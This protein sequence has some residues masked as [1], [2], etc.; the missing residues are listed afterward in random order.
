MSSLS[1]TVLIS[2]GVSFR[3]SSLEKKKRTHPGGSGW[4]GGREWLF[5]VA[6]LVITCTGVAILVEA[7]PT[8][9]YTLSMLHQQRRLAGRALQPTS[10]RGALRLAGWLR[11]RL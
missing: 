1:P 7:V 8:D 11:T 10:A 6:Q 9:G 5:P 2:S 3:I 4:L